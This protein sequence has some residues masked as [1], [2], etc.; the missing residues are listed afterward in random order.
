M[1]KEIMFD[2]L[3]V[4]VTGYY[5]E[6]NY[7]WPLVCECD[8]AVEDGQYLK[9]QKLLSI[10]K[11]YNNELFSCGRNNGILTVCFLKRQ[12]NSN[13]VVENNDMIFLLLLLDIKI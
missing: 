3:C 4:N 6:R 9:N 7:V 13:L 12:C 5:I 2:L 1:M 8:W 10:F 11:W